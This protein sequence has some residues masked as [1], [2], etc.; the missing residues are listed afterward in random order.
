MSRVLA[1]HEGAAD[2]PLAWVLPGL[3][4]VVLALR[5]LQL[6]FSGASLHVDE[7]QYWDW[8]RQLQ[9]GYHSKPPLIAWLIAASTA[10]F[11]ESEIG[12][13]ALNLLCWPAAAAALGWLA[14]DIAGDTAAAAWAALVW[15][16]TPLAGTLG[17]VATTDGPLVLLWS[18]ALLMLW[19]ASVRAR[20]WAWWAL[21]LVLGLGLLAKY[22]MAALLVGAWLF[23][24]HRRRRPE[25]IG[26]LQA[27]TLALLLLLPH[28]AWSVREGWVTLRHTA[29]ITLHADA[30]AGRAGG[31]QAV[32][33][34]LGGQALALAPLLLPWCLWGRRLRAAE[35]ATHLPW[36][37]LLAWTSAPLLLAGL[38]Q[39][40]RSGV[41]INWL[42]PAHLA[43]AL[44]LGL[45]IHA[46]SARGQR[47]AGA[48]LLLQ[49]VL[50]AGLTL[51]PAWAAAQQRLLPPW[52]DA[53]ARMRGW[54]E[55][56][57]QFVP[58]LHRH[59]A[60]RVLTA[61]RSVMAQAAY[62]WRGQGL[63]RLAW[64]PGGPARH[65]YESACPWR[66]GQPL[67]THV[68]LDEPPAAA[69]QA[70]LGPLA[71]E[72]RAVV[73]L[74]HSRTRELVLWRVMQAPPQ[75]PQGPACR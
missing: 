47:R 38:L 31:L 19:L 64:A 69:L 54:G 20:P 50:V 35:P 22:T 16:A 75:A 63:A 74:T 32:A 3:L 62:H 61:S 29:D 24:L 36:R 17:L 44:W 1:T 10:L 42:A 58:V 5:L 39:A 27:S 7:A 66:P 9:A 34:L 11:G 26:L 8:S 18:L 25:W 45:A 56:L 73:P 52:A 48:L 68:L 72:A 57:R 46:A 55:P 4:A 23:V 2:T 12:V 70:A 37:G 40:W 49:A 65:H 53:W 41:Q 60:P 51:L 14:A 33:A 67:P 28:L 59:P 30:A 71:V 21:G 6:A 43:L 13:R 15:L